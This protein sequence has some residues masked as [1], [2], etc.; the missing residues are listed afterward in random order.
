[1][2]FDPISAALDFG[3]KLLD[4]FVQDPAQK[5][6]AALQLL[7]M[8]QSGELQQMVA[9][10]DV[11]KTEAA[12]PNVFISGWRPFVGWICATAFGVNYIIGPMGTW[13]AALAGHPI[14]FPNIDVTS[15]MPVLLGM[16]GLGAYRTY[17]KVNDAAGN[18]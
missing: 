2:A 18:H 11:D 15:M 17:E 16:L 5:A 10:L 13:I 8:Q 3:G 1:M 6:Q 9:Q 14:A 4:K 12:N 7:Q